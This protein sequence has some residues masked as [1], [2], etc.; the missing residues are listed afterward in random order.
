MQTCG[1]MLSF[2]IALVPASL[3]SA[4]IVKHPVPELPCTDFGAQKWTR[5]QWRPLRLVNQD[6]PHEFVQN[7]DSLSAFFSPELIKQQRDNALLA[8]EI[9]VPSGE[10]RVIFS[11]GSEPGAAAGVFIGK[12]CSSDFFY[13]GTV[14]FVADNRLA[15]W[16]VETDRASKAVKY[17]HLGQLAHSFAVGEKHILKCS[18]DQKGGIAISVDNTDVLSFRNCPVGP[19]LGIWGCHGST[20]FFSAEARNVSTLHSTYQSTLAR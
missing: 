1:L 14:I 6:A 2:L 9:G 13:S 18:F 17:T 16:T 8:A 4:E 12:D 5:S 10:L 19:T 11:I 20:T 15:I 3:I 7:P